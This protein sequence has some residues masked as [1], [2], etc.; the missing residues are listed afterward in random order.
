MSA[1]DTASSRRVAD[2]IESQ[3]GSWFPP[4]S[5]QMYRWATEIRALADALD[6]ARAEVADL[7][8]E[9]EEMESV[10]EA[11]AEAAEAEVARLRAAMPDAD[12]LWDAANTANAHGWRRATVA[13]IRAAAH[14]IRALNATVPGG[15]A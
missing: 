8:E 6:A 4:P 10:L 1:V 7:C 9:A 14:R 5:P 11:R 12:M 3:A 2:E 15:A 13:E